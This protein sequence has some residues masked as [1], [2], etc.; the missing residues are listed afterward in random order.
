LSGPD[1]AN[2]NLALVED[3]FFAALDLSPAG[4]EEL[5]HRHPAEVREE[6]L[7]LLMEDQRGS[8]VQRAVRG[9]AGSLIESHNAETLAIRAGDRLG[10]YEIQHELGSGG[11]GSVYL[12]VRADDTY[13]RNVAVKF[14]RREFDTA[15]FRQRFAQERRIL[16][17]LDHPYIARL[18]DAGS[19]PTGQPYFVMEFV[20]GA[21]PITSYAEE[22]RLSVS[23]RIELFAKVCEAVQY[24][25]QN[26][27]VHRD[28]KPGNIL[29]DNTGTPK[30][31]DFGIAKLTS[32]DGCTTDQTIAA[33][34]RMLTPDYASPEHASGM[35]VTTSTD[36]YSLGA[37]LY[38]LLT[39]ERP[40]RLAEGQYEIDPARSLGPDLGGI[41]RMAMH[42]NPASRYATA[43]ALRDDLLRHLNG[44]QIRA[45]SYSWPERAMYFGRRYATFLAASTTV[46]AGLAVAA[47]VAVRAANVA[48]QARQEAV[49]ER[50]SAED[51]RIDAIASSEESARMRQ[52]AEQERNIARDRARETTAL[53]SQLIR[54]LQDKIEG[55]PGAGPARL[56]SITIAI[57]YLERLA[58]DR[59][60]GPEAQRELALAYMRLADLKG[61]GGTMNNQGDVRAAQPYLDKAERILRGPAGK[62]P[63]AK[64][65]MI[66]LLARQT[67][68]F[69]LLGDIPNSDRALQEGLRVAR[70]MPVAAALRSG[71]TDLLINGSKA[72]NR[73]QEYDRVF[74]LTRECQRAVPLS[75]P[76]W[77][78]GEALPA[79]VILEARAHG[80]RGELTKAVDLLKRGIEMREAQLAKQPANSSARKQ[81]MLAYSHL[82]AFL[83]SPSRAS[84]G[85]MPGALQ[86]MAKVRDHAIWN[87][88]SDPGDMGAQKDL[89][90]S[91]SR[92]GDLLLGAKNYAE[93]VAQLG[94]AV[95]LFQAYL[96]RL[97]GDRQVL[98]ELAFAAKRQGDAL[99][100]LSKTDSPAAMGAYRK[101]LA[102]VD[103]LE[104]LSPQGMTISSYATAIQ[105]RTR[106][107]QLQVGKAP[108]EAEFQ[109]GRA[110]EQARILLAANPQS[111]KALTARLRSVLTDAASIYQALGRTER[112]VQCR[113]ELANT[114]LDPAV[115][116]AASTATR[117]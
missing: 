84:L 50:N 88:R 89:A 104:K 85:D 51:A 117:R 72:A 62:S 23:A 2:P 96:R 20:A 95:E 9:A 98:P 54:D 15:L 36:I 56:E 28:L 4:R 81:T 41:L 18:L 30:L 34:L 32:T 19:T 109:I 22:V 17:R 83:G 78:A 55:L 80:G 86:A 46:A 61:G 1:T 102:A 106:I 97:P 94:D 43:A 68:F 74:E 3:L 90:I 27:T 105:L 112:A 5:L 76:E 59:D 42:R 29:I 66:R 92:Y 77:D 99:S 101:G 35:P 10:A 58:G 110:L 91:S 108:A 53:T 87:A 52:S 45:R 79:C 116:N 24:A 33:G 107:A 57:Q 25:H 26:L 13:H 113:T 64:P 70:A 14:V 69:D 63:A 71:F 93:A 115:T 48:E 37:I 12:A 11:M 103:E 6:V 65:L 39:G 75:P 40:P 47:V 7:A 16:G 82:S 44:K 111:S 73:R 67:E 100:Q 21:R 8:V 49:R 114:P 31:L 38:E 60:A